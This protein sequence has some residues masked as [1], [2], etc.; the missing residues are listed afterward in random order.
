MV[1]L[2]PVKM[3][4]STSS[5]VDKNSKYYASN[6]EFETLILKVT[7]EGFFVR[8]DLGTRRGRAMDRERRDREMRIGETSPYIS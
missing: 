8:F 2:F 1:I 5:S 7:I 4:A 6:I 3:P